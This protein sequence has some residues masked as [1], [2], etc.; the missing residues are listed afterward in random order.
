[1]TLFSA[2]TLT[3]ASCEEGHNDFPQL[4]RP[5]ASL[6][7]FMEQYAPAEQQFTVDATEE[8]RITGEKGIEVTFPGGSLLDGNDQPVTGEVTI[9]LIEL[10][11]KT[12]IMLSG[13]S[14]ES[15][16]DLLESGGEFY[17]VAEQ[18]GEALTLN[19]INGQWT[20]NP[21]QVR[22]PVAPD[23]APDMI[24][25]SGGPSDQNPEELTWIVSNDRVVGIDKGYYAFPLPDLNWTNLDKFA[26][27]PGDRTNITVQVTSNSAGGPLDVQ[28][29]LVFKDMKSVIGMP[30]STTAGTWYDDLLP[31][32]LEVT[33]VAIGSDASGRLYLGSMDIL[34]AEDQT[35]TV[36]A[37]QVNDQEAE[38]FMQG[39]NQ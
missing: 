16:G 35:Y 37:E 22:F 14:T 34:T 1:M 6:A 13:L 4:E 3:L 20:N 31:V 36:H 7:S 39:L 30:G 9:R 11:S 17:L 26:N 8:F 25:F 5:P 23:N 24:L 21:V 33:I 27:Y 2:L 19:P 12:D 32:G 38:D 18:D 10:Y 29:W 28:A 15:Q